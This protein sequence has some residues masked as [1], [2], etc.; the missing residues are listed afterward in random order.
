[1]YNILVVDD[2]RDVADVLTWGLEDIKGWKVENALTVEEAID[3]KK[4][5]D[6]HIHGIVLDRRFPGH[7]NPKKVLE[8]MRKTYPEARILCYSGGE[9]RGE[10][11]YD[12]VLP[13]PALPGE[14]ADELERIID[15]N[16]T[17]KYN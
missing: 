12:S 9:V 4:E 10:H 1:M 17:L 3:Y 8:I 16:V 6:V 13:K 5:E 7:T 14:V 2:D 11:G 15:K